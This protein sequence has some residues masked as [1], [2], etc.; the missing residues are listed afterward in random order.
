MGSQG[1][2][3]SSRS[4]V[5]TST[6]S[7][8][9]EST[10]VDVTIQGKSLSLKS[11]RDESFVKELA[12]YVDQKL[13]TF[14]QA[15]PKAPTDKLLMMVSLTITEELFEAEAEAD[16]LRDEVAERTEKLRDLIGQLSD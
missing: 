13:E 14:S 12:N 5:T 6:K 8:T 16:E 1:S 10:S 4:N 2:N 15:A 7:E 9:R 3:S 11:D